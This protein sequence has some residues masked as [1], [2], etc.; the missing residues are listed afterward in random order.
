MK[1]PSGHQAPLG[2]PTTPSCSADEVP[3]VVVDD[4][5]FEPLGAGAG[6]PFGVWGV[7]DVECPQSCSAHV[8][9]FY[10]GAVWWG[11]GARTSV[12]VGRS[13]R[14]VVDSLATN[15]VVLD[16]RGGILAVNEG[17]P[18]FAAAT[19]GDPGCLGLGRAISRLAR[20]RCSSSPM[21]AECLRALRE[22]AAGER[23]SFGVEYRCDLPTSQRWFAMHATL[24][25]SGGSERIV[26]MHADITERRR[27]GAGRRRDSLFEQL[28]AAVLASDTDGRVTEW[29]DAAE[30]LYGWS[31]AE[32]LHQRVRDRLIPQSQLDE[33]DERWAAMELLG[34]WE[35]EFTA[36]GA[37]AR[38]SRR[39]AVRWRSTTARAIA[40]DM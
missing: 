1:L 37:T 21:A 30:R 10:P 27:R 16:E 8:T 38:R 14:T 34:R 28:D 31:R 11:R 7:P 18:E 36:R 24:F 20:A 15:V 33:R 9:R 6:I 22:M 17:W 13:W 29:N 23:D 26:V 40:K 39:T 3:M 12:R 19:G 2:Y 35:G 5:L 32:V 4:K 25:R